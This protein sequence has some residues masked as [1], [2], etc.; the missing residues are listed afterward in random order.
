[1]YG[2]VSPCL[3]VYELEMCV[4]ALPASSSL[5]AKFN[6]I[7]VAVLLENFV[8][9][10]NKH[11]TFKRIAEEAREH[12][13]YAGALDPLLATLANFTSPQVCDQGWFGFIPV[14]F[15]RDYDDTPR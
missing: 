5:F 12:H 2:C 15:H 3:F 10:M 11:D 9:S 6:Q 14:L 8:S 4:S 13:K 1:M 7:I